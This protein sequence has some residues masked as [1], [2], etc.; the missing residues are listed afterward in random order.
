MNNKIV[1][2]KKTNSI[3][4]PSVLVSGLIALSSLS[5]M[6]AGAQTHPYY[7]M[8]NKYNSYKP[9]YGM[10]NDRKSYGK[11]IYESQYPS[12]PPNYRPQY[13]GLKVPPG[14]EICFDRLDNNGDELRDFA[15]PDC[16]PV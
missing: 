12:Y 16:P 13:P 2:T 1:S 14:I 7:G 6:T 3:F 10:D 5:F 8:D 11:D 4:L 15:D 9:D